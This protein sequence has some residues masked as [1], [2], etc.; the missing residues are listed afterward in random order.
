MELCNGRIDI[1]V[2]NAGI[3]TNKSFLDVSEKIWDEIVETNAKGLFFVSQAISHVW[4]AKKQGGKIL[5]I[6]SMRGF[7]GVVDG[8][9]GM[10]KWGV[11]GLTRGLGATLLPYGIF[12]NGIA[13]GAIAGADMNKVLGR[14]VGCNDNLAF[15]LAPI[16]RFGLPE[17]IAE[18]ALFLM[19]DAANYIVG[20][21]IICDG[22]YTL[23]V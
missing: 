13:P 11:V 7:L 21:T 4:I 22:G 2:N 16:Q 20:Q 17:E 6:S 8:P 3:T 12:V 5:N 18:L 14:S 23:K 15:P 1:L 19:S 10:S 9:Y